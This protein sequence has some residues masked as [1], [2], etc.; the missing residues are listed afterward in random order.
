MNAFIQVQDFRDKNPKITS[1]W[2]NLDRQLKAAASNG[3]DF[4]IEILVGG[5]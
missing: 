5:H 1:A 2:K 4:Q 3:D